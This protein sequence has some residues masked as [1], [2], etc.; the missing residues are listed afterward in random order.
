MHGHVHHHTILRAG[1]VVSLEGTPF[2]ADEACAALSALAHR[3]PVLASCIQRSAPLD[4]YLSPLPSSATASTESPSPLPFE[5]RPRDLGAQT[6]QAF[7]ST[8]CS[9]PTHDGEP[10]ARLVQFSSGDSDA[11]ELLIVIEHTICDGKSLTA[12]TH[13]LLCLLAGVP[14]PSTVELGF[15]QTLESALTQHAGGYLA[16]GLAVLRAIMSPALHP[17]KKT[18]VVRINTQV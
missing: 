9:E 10:L 8:E 15:T 2:S 4:P 5:M 14:P 3:H 16:Q 7:W 1:V 11:F 12:L 6:A 17:P 13:E 18:Q